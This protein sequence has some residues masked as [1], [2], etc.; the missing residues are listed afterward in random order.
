M[1][2]LVAIIL[3]LAVWKINF[4]ISVGD[5]M[6]KNKEKVEILLKFMHLFRP[7]F[8]IFSPFLGIFSGI[9]G[10]FTYKVCYWWI[11]VDE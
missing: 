2:V 1:V 8:V 6:Y 4:G 7:I 9:W 3:L 10:D 5:G 11:L